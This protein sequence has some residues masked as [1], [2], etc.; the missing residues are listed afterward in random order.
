MEDLYPDFDDLLQFDEAADPDDESAP[1]Q[2][3]EILE[4][5]IEEENIQPALKLDYKLKTC[6][7]RADLVNQIVAQTPKDHLTNRYLEIL[8][9]YIMG[10]ITKEEKKS[11]DYLTDNRRITIDRRETSFEG[12][13]EKFENGEDG[14]YNL[15]TN[16]KNIIFQHKQEITQEDIDTIPGLK[17]LRQ[18]IEI[19][20]EEGKAATGKRKYLLKK[21]LI[22]MRKD[23][24]ILKSS[25]KA[26]IHFAPSPKGMNKI[27]LSER[28]YVDENGE[29]QSTGL[30]TFFNP[31]HISAILCNYS[32]LKAE[33]RGKY[34]NDFYYL[35][36]DFD[37]LVKKALANYPMYAELVK[38][39][40]RGAQNAEI[41]EMIEKKYNE[42][43]SSQYISSLWRNRIPK[44]IAERA[45]DDFL[46][47]YYEHEKQGAMKRCACCGQRK[48]ANS[49]FFSKNKTS[50]DGWYSW[51]KECRKIKNKGKN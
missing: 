8:G 34:W 5:K 26:P 44:I 15:M 45:K 43:H 40:I 2:E 48:P 10:G 1:E 18:N 49:H 33:T 32:A 39:K 3:A 23:Q 22:D 35:I 41:Q 47:W 27:D 36:N 38:M 46:I 12:L 24:Y 37:I 11:R 14:I 29:P 6:Q 31:E 20:E 30:I 7:E 19:I 25:F 4:S 16:D 42:K 21:W 50:K 51:C 28:Q 17:E 9:D 13:A